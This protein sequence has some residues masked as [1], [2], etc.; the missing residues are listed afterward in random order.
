MNMTTAITFT[1]DSILRDPF[2]A[3][4]WLRD[5]APVYKDP[6]SGTYIVSRY[7]DIQRIAED[8]ET[9][10]NNTKMMSDRAFQ[11]EDEAGRIMREF[12]TPSIDT[13]VTADPPIHTNYRAIVQGAFRASRISKMQAYIQD[14]CDKQI[15]TFAEKNRF[16]VLSDLAIPMPMYIIADQLGVPRDMYETFKRWSD[17][18]LII[19]DL[20]FSPEVRADC[21]RSIVEMHNYLKQMAVRYRQTPEGNVLSD[22]ANGEVDGR[23]L[24]DD[25]VVS[26]GQQVLVAGNETTTNTMAMGLHLMIEQGLEAE[27]RS[28]ISKIPQFV[29]ETL[30]MTTA[31]QGLFRRATREVEVA[32]TTIPAN[33]ILMLRWASGNRDERKFANPDV[34]DLS[35]KMAMQH[36]AFGM[37]IHYCLGNLLARAELRTAFA[38]LLTRFKNFRFLNEPDSQRWVVHTWARGMNRL[39]LEFDHV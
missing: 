26:I 1:D 7:A 31:L 20:H 29:E 38:T 30:R 39:V 37:G 9:F 18:L 19:G 24:S 28:D 11:I 17:A 25:E 22:I 13:I 14:V 4:K 32:G 6:I 36:L 2:P 35:R 27:L 15:E 23:K 5:N 34:V 33:A 16:E 12:A 21:A 8:T 10:S 3:Y